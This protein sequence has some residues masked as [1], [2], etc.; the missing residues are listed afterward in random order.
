MGIFRKRVSLL[1]ALAIGQALRQGK[2]QLIGKVH[3]QSGGIF[4]NIAECVDIQPYRER[5]Q[6]AARQR[7]QEMDDSHYWELSAEEYN[8]MCSKYAVLA[9]VVKGA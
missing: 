9:E 1:D 7:M 3:M 4:L 5:L 6:A 8:E 2:A